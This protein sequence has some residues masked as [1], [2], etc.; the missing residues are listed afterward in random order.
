MFLWPKEKSPRA[1]LLGSWGHC[2]QVSKESA[3]RDSNFWLLVNKQTETGRR[4]HKEKAPDQ[5]HIIISVLYQQAMKQNPY[6]HSAPSNKIKQKQESL[7]FPKSMAMI[8]S[9]PF[10]PSQFHFSY[11]SL[12]L[13]PLSSPPFSSTQLNL[14]K[15]TL[16]HPKMSS[17]TSCQKRRRITLGDSKSPFSYLVSASGN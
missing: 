8:F 7:P 6:M 4:I 9:G 17:V 2:L 16:L 11:P 14:S 12:L 10:S 3:T 15:F 5:T 1:A 13:N